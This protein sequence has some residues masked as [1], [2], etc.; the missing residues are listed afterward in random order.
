MPGG[1]AVSDVT[2]VL[3][4]LGRLCEAGAGL[5]GP[6]VATYTAV[7][8]SDTAIPAW[9]EPWR[10]LPFVFAGGAGASAGAAAVLITPAADAGPARRLAVL[11]AVLEVGAELAMERRLGDLAE[12]Y[13]SG[14]AGRWSTLAKGALAAGA[15]LIA[16]GGRR[17]RAGALG[18]ALVLAGTALT[19]W[20][21]FK[22]GFA[23]AEDPKYVVAPQRERISAR[24][25]GGERRP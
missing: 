25:G 24:A 4:R 5:L 11:G 12:P 21:I 9:H 22:A 8:T 23:S 1:E 3:P 20:S 15:S 18:A 7:L 17:R 16:L 13:R 10:E 14:D 19:R 6:A 2:G